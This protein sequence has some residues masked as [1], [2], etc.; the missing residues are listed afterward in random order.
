MSCSFTINEPEPTVKTHFFQE[1]QI[2][3]VVARRGSFTIASREL[4]LS[5]S[6][7]S[8]AIR[9]LEEHVGVTLLARTTRSVAPTEAGRRLLGRVGPSLDD[10]EA[11]MQEV[12]A[13][14]GD[15]VGRL[16]LTVPRSAGP[17]I[18]APVLP[19]F[20]ARH[21]RVAVE[22]VLDDRLVDIVAE[23]F[24][25]GVRLSEAID[26]DM[27]QVRLT[28]PF[29]FVVV[30]APAYLARRP[31]PRAPEELLRHECIGFN[32]PRSGEVYAWELER[33]ER[34]WRVPVQ[35]GVL[36]NDAELRLAL[37]ES[38]LGLTYAAEPTALAAIQAGRLSVVLAEYAA[39]VPGFFLY[40]PSRAQRSS[41][42]V[43]F[44]E[45]AREVLVMDHRAA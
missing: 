23:G 33:G 21:P 32:L 44:I 40:Y 16:R 36:C 3:V 15:V 9:R 38:G 18:I 41:A 11:A 25:A 27:V 20:R 8:Q 2:F 19:V 1:L 29:R 26:L 6:A 43:R 7:T 45:T 12:T 24:D 35:C 42:L 5:P 14:P 4:G 34:A 28:S 10:T 37:A 39:H 17:R 30:G 13:E 31:E 22:V